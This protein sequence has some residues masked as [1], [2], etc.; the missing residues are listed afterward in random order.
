MAENI[1]T[2]VGAWMDGWADRWTQK[3]FYG[4]LTAIKN[5]NRTLNN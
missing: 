3:Q 5:V 2:V 1:K 4:L